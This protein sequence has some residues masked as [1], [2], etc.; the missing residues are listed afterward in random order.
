MPPPKVFPNVVDNDDPSTSRVATIV[1][2]LI[3]SLLFVGVLIF[4]ATWLLR[5]CRWSRRHRQQQTRLAAAQ[6][7]WTQLTNQQQ[8]STRNQGPGEELTSMETVSAM[9]HQLFPILLFHPDLLHAPRKSTET[10]IRVINDTSGEE[11]NENDKDICS[12]CLETYQIG[13]Q[14]RWLLPCGHFFHVEVSICF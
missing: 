3:L 12:I 11:T 1:I 14:V 9:Q 8:T 7:R 5:V 6:N 2:Y 10:N 13:E 4:F